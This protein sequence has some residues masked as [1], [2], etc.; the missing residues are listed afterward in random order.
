MKP[1]PDSLQISM[2]SAERLQSRHP[3]RYETHTDHDPTQT[4]LFGRKI[5]EI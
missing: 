3:E 2:E 4:G 5:E 1:F